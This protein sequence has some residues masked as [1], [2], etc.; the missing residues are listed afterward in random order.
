[1]AHWTLCPIGAYV[2][3]PQIKLLEMKWMKRSQKKALTLRNG[4]IG[5]RLFH[6]LNPC[7]NKKK[8][9]AEAFLCVYGLVSFVL[10]VISHINLSCPESIVESLKRP[11]EWKC[12]PHFLLT[13]LHSRGEI[14][15]FLGVCLKM[16][17]LPFPE[18]C[19]VPRE[20]LLKSK[21]GISKVRGM[22]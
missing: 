20:L 21:W 6:L 14:R 19:V 13:A 11:R 18:S 16:P 17:K 2:Y 8:H 3:T 5:N 1:M 22:C 4:Y 10:A 9:G 12:Y 15:F 7:H